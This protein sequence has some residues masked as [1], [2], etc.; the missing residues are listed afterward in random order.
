MVIPNYI[1]YADGKST[2]VRE[3]IELG[4]T[5]CSVKSNDNYIF[6]IIPTESRLSIQLCKFVVCPGLPIVLTN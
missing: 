5:N 6:Y 4:H 2:V 3:G 1:Y